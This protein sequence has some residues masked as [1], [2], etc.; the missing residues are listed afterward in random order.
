MIH[1]QDALAAR[2]QS[3]VPVKAGPVS[4]VANSGHRPVR[5]AESGLRQSTH[6]ELRRVRCEFHEGAL[7]LRGRVSSFYLKQLAQTLAAATPGV[8][9]VVNRIEVREVTRVSA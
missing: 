4:S 9:E 5:Q 8:Q 7:V 6:S 1:Q 3:L 2:G